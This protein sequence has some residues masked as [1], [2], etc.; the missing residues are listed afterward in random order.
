MLQNL[1]IDWWVNYKTINLLKKYWFL[2][3]FN[4]SQH[5]GKNHR[6]S[7]FCL[8]FRKVRQLIFIKWLNSWKDRFLIVFNNSYFAL[9]KKNWWQ[10]SHLKDK[11]C[12]EN[13][14]AAYWYCLILCQENVDTAYWC[15]L[16]LC[17]DSRECWCSLL[18]LF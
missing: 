13:V 18:M 1:L 14:D 12:Q 10:I 4:K 11:L 9:F 7:D 15:C 5:F 3:V 16:I 17:Q 6:S 2:A 8:F